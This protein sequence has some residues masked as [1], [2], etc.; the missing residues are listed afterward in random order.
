MSSLWGKDVMNMRHAFPPVLVKPED[1]EQS[2]V[3]EIE[4]RPEICQT[5]RQAIDSQDEYNIFSAIDKSGVR[6]FW[7]IFSCFAGPEEYDV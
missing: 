2:A 6:L 7:H 4:E 3:S 1:T 5:C